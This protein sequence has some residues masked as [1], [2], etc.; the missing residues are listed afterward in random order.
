MGVGIEKHQCLETAKKKKKTIVN[1]GAKE[2]LRRERMTMKND[3]KH[4]CY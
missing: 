2:T 1:V 3:T 4:D